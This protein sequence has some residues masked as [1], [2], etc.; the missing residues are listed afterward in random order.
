MEQME[1][2]HVVDGCQCEGKWCNDCERIVCL[3]D[4]YPKLH[5]RSKKPTVTSY[6]RVCHAARTSAYAK[7]KRKRRPTLQE[8]FSTELAKIDTQ[9]GK[10]WIWQGKI[11]GGYGIFQTWN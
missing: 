7:S 2:N 10:C 1:I 4:F 5:H 8:R 11:H 9:P 6:C 3:A